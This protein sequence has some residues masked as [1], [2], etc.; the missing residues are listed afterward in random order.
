MS[1][2][3][4]SA[5]SNRSVQNTTLNPKCQPSTQTAHNAQCC[6]SLDTSYIDYKIKPENHAYARGIPYTD[7]WQ[8]RPTYWR[9]ISSLEHEGPYWNAGQPPF[10]S[11]NMWDNY[12]S[13]LSL[14]PVKYNSFGIPSYFYSTQD[15]RPWYGTCACFKGKIDNRCSKG[16]EPVCSWQGDG[17][18]CTCVKT[19]DCNYNLPYY[20]MNCGKCDFGQGPYSGVWS[21]VWSG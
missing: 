5:S 14:D 16:Y 21:G 6:P 17:Q 20:Q 18:Q 19:Q 12:M 1:N 15:T 10:Y 8:A 3:P 7:R 4:L 2:R 13:Y 11:K 9:D